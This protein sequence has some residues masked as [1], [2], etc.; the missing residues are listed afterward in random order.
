[1]T[2]LALVVAFVGWSL[3]AV[4]ATSHLFHFPTLVE[5]LAAHVS[6]DKQRSTR[7]RRARMLARYLV[8]TEVALSVGVALSWMLGLRSLVIVV[9]GAAA[10]L[11]AG[12]CLWLIRLITSGSDLPCA[13]TTSGRPPTW[14][15]LARSIPVM[16]TALFPLLDT[17]PSL[18]DIS[19][20]AL[21]AFAI[22]LAL[23]VLPDAMTWP[24]FSRELVSA[25]TPPTGVA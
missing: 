20:T 6:P 19:L 18:L 12:F 24:R 21:A 4:G 23:F 14:W 11:G 10:L 1:M 16:G 3:L 9:A 7:E 13:C 5:Q 15:S 25:A 17:T 22:G 2:S 8:A